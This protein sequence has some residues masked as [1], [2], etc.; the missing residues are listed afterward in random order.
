MPFI[1][2]T[3]VSE[4]LC[5]LMWWWL[6]GERKKVLLEI[7]TIMQTQKSGWCWYLLLLLPQPVTIY[8]CHFSFLVNSVGE[9]GE[10][11][12]FHLQCSNSSNHFPYRHHRYYQ[13]LGKGQIHEKFPKIFRLTDASIIV[14][15]L[16]MAT[17]NLQILSHM[18]ILSLTR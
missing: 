2:Y 15:F 7:P 5:Q 3:A 10:S 12:W 11:T 4:Q 6:Y 8:S 17:G 1:L 9:K 14:W 16:L 13:Q 18:P